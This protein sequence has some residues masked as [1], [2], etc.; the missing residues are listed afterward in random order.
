MLRPCLIQLPLPVAR[1]VSVPHGLYMMPG[2]SLDLV[3]NVAMNIP[4]RHKLSL[5]GQKGSVQLANL[6]RDFIQESSTLDEIVLEAIAVT[7]GSSERAAER[8]GVGMDAKSA[9]GEDQG[10]VAGAPLGA[11]SYPQFVEIFLQAR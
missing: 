3:E 2:S 4:C 5:A 6:D 11:R 9:D 1:E 8:R 10:D 7:D